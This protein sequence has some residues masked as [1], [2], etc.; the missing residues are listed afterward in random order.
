MSETTC[1]R[2]ADW[3]VAWD[4]AEARHGFL[5][6]ADVAFRGEDIVHVGPAYEGAVDHEIDGRDL[7]VMPGLVDVHSH[8]MSEPMNKGVTDEM[9]SRRL[10]MSGLY[11]YMP[12]FRPDAEGMAAC[13]ELAYAELLRSGVTTLVDLSVPWDGWLELMAKSGLRGVLAPMYRSARWYTSNGYSVEY[14]WDEKAG[15]RAFEVALGLID[16]A[17][18]HPSGRL[19]GML[20]PSQVDTCSEALLRD[21]VAAAEERDL[22]LQIHASQ[23]VVEF[24]EMTRR[25]GMTPVE[26]LGEIGFLGPGATIAHCIFLDHHSWV[27]WPDRRDLDLL[28]ETG[29]SVAHCPTVFVRRGILLQNFGA[30]VKA[31]VNV[32][33]GTDT[34][35]HN[36]LE[37]IRTAATLSRVAA[38]DVAVLG[39]GE[40]FHAATIGGANILQRDDIGRLEPGAKADIVLVE[41]RHPAMQPLRDP[42]RSLV[43]AAAERAVRDVYVGG[44]KVVADGAVLGLDHAGAA[45][46]VTEAQRRAE[47]RV[48]ERDYAGRRHDELVPLSLPML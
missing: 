20:T 4:R 17:R 30:Y 13:A 37:E 36:F 8:P 29:T 3:V 40:A 12:A 47:T 6:D 34:F 24:N 35:P 2:N 1:V 33:L 19:D 18:Q 9:G 48:P 16:R 46:R 23:S 28:V 5:R 14:E 22:A 43:Y 27:R 25:H 26:W 32:G 21:S 41:A 7:V 39:T 45:L 44:R 42:L 10:G 38:E 15:R 31:G 11:E